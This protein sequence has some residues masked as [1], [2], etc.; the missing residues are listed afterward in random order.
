MRAL[1][2]ALLLANVAFWAWTRGWLDGVVGVSPEAERE[3]QRV[4]RQ[5]EPQRLR[6]LA[7]GDAARGRPAGA[8]TQPAAAP[9]HPAT[10]AP[11][12]AASAAASV[13]CLEAGPFTPAEAI[14][15]EAALVRAALPAGSWTDRLTE[16]PGTWIVYL[17]RYTTPEQAAQREGELRA[18]RIAVEPVR[19][20]DLEPGLSL[21]SFDSR[22]AADA[23]LAALAQRGVRNARVLATAPPSVTHLLR[24]ERADAA[25]QAQLA[26]L[27]NA[28]ALGRG[29]VPCATPT[30]AR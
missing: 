1:V 9:T 25:L 20:P 12:A 29:F 11:T 7:A 21:G 17:G 22:P 23:A 5:V 15:A 14:A 16:R 26:V 24:I 30:A 13:Q 3:P 10:P 28:P 4:Q 8:P 18:Q 6:I 27:D 19:L 2:V